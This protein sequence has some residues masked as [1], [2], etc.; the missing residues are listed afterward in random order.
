[1][2]V[3]SDP[4]QQVLQDRLTKA[5][6]TLEVN[7]SAKAYGA[8][9]DAVIRR[10]EVRLQDQ[11]DNIAQDEVRLSQLQTAREE[12]DK[13]IESLRASSA[14][15][16]KIQDELD[17]VKIERDGLAKK[18]NA[19]DKYKQKLQANQDLEYENRELRS[20]IEELRLQSKAEGEDRQ[21]AQGL[22]MTMQQYRKTIEQVEQDYSELQTMK[23]RLELDNA[24]LTQ[25]WESMTEQQ[26]RDA[27]VISDLQEK[28][29]E[30]ET[31]AGPRLEDSGNL[32]RELKES[33]KSKAELKADVSKLKADIQALK[34][35]SEAEA[36]NV[37]LQ[38]LLQD[39]KRKVASL[40]SKYLETYQAQ[41]LLES[42]LNMI[43]QGAAAEGYV[44]HLTTPAPAHISRRSEAAIKL[45][46][47]HVKD[48]DELSDV[49]KRLAA[50]EAD[51]SVASRELRQARLDRT[52]T[53]SHF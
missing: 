28:L 40:E 19:L 44:R 13:T 35:G 50:L 51:A 37:M 48:R 22:E 11:E 5:E 42:Q 12:Q 38:N 21:R 25:R 6:D 18:A 30:L 10:L 49:N 24:A 26:S 3:A 43:K 32:E 39:A 23:R 46:E 15:A 29:R 31:G 33:G 52:C 16:L 27:E 20:E 17:E 7:G 1:M 45:R 8:D 9:A 41:L 14:S 4:Q 53:Q 2:A 34:A 36:K 47:T